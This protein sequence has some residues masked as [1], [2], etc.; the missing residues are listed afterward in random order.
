MDFLDINIHNSNNFT[1]ES[2]QN[3]CFI[4]IIYIY[5]M[6]LFIMQDDGDEDDVGYLLAIDTIS[7][8]L[9]QYGFGSINNGLGSN[10][11][12]FHNLSTWC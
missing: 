8:R 5:I 3:Y 7:I 9:L 6:H 1:T 11:Q 2:K 12:C 4:N 10:T